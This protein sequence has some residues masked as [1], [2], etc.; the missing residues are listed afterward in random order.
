MTGFHQTDYGQAWRIP[1]L[2]D[3]DGL[4]DWNRGHIIEVCDGDNIVEFIISGEVKMDAP[5]VEIEVISPV[6]ES[7]LSNDTRATIVHAVSLTTM[8]VVNWKNL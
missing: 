5:V 8:E 6:P 2:E 1:S 4:L 7:Y 3:T